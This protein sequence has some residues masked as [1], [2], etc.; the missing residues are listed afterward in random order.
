MIVGAIA[1][2]LVGFVVF[3]TMLRPG[4]DSQTLLIPGET[5]VAIDEPGEYLIWAVQNGIHDGQLYAG[6]DSLPHGARS[7]VTRVDDG[8]SIPL[9]PANGAMSSTIGSRTSTSVAR[10]EIDAPG[11]YN[12]SVQGG[13]S[14]RVITI[15]RSGFASVATM[16]VP[17]FCASLI[18][19]GMGLAGLTVLI[20]TIVG[21][22]R[23]P[24]HTA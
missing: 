16:L 21:H 14:P 8:A 3:F 17:F 9:L 2:Y 5:V 20:V 13:F 24:S 15:G 12:I 23:S 4:N 19:M 10:F 1:L 11:E 22:A 18:S 6:S 7:G